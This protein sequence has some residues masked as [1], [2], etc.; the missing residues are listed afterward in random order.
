[1]V[2]LQGFL[3]FLVYA[4]P[5][6]LKRMEERRK[7]SRRQLQQS[8]KTNA[9]TTN[10][11]VSRRQVQQESEDTAGTLGKVVLGALSVSLRE[12]SP[13]GTS[14]RDL[15]S[16]ELIPEMIEMIEMIEEESDEDSVVG[17]GIGIEENAA[18]IEKSSPDASDV[19]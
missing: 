1:L 4:R 2:P 11:N 13:A 10:N 17:E 9:A 5:R 3:N 8:A 6:I 14:K 15:S 16:K 19:V 7:M 12:D 18:P